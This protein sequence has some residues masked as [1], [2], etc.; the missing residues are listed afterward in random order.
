M[1]FTK[2]LISAV[3]FF[4]ISFSAPQIAISQTSSEITT[5]DMRDMIQTDR[6]SVQHATETTGTPYLFPDFH[7]GHILLTN[8]QKTNVLEL[9]FNTYEQTL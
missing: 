2:L 5:E 7:D 1:K 6:I 3:L 9:R 8:G 4:T